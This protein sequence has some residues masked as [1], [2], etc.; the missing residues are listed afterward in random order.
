MS[1]FRTTALFYGCC[2]DRIVRQKN[3]LIVKL[4][5][6]KVG[7]DHFDPDP[8]AHAEGLSASFSNKAVVLLYVAE[9]IVILQAHD[10]Y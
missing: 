5:F 3:P 1:F 4:S 2:R 9:I 6:Y 10:A 7:S 8:V